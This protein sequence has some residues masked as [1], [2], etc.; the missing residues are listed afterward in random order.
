[1]T[2]INALIQPHLTDLIAIRH[3]LHAHPE[4]GYEEHR[5]S[6]VV[7]RELA[8]AGVDFKA[9]LA[10]GTGVLAHLPGGDGDPIA[11]RADMDALPIVEQTGLPYAS[12]T[13]GRMHAC[14]HDGHTAILIGVAQVLAAMAKEDALPRPVTLVFQPAEEG[15]AGGARMVQDGCLDGSV[16]GPA[17]RSIFG[18]HGWPALGLGQVASRPGPILASADG[19]EA[20]ITGRGGHAAMPHLCIDPIA[21][22]AAVI[23]SAQHVI[24]RKVDPVQG[25]VVSITRVEGGTT[26]NIIPETVFM[27][28]TTRFLHAEAGEAI[29]AAFKEILEGVAAAHGC[30]AEI[31]MHEG[32][33]ITF[34]DPEA[35][36]WWQRIAVATFGPQRVETMAPVMGGE[37]FSYY[38]QQ[39][40]ACFFA[41]GLQPEGA[42]SMPGLHHPCFD[43]NDDAI[44]MGIEAFVAVA[45]H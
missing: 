15:G 4:L 37:D 28:G 5:T 16:L 3:D 35:Y 39:I 24:A 20:T 43:F 40:P 26:H 10:G 12:R 32:Y 19:F 13:E 45:C 8:A 41:L 29:H 27:Q 25:G 6:E 33:P 38:G 34:N 36:A 18:L 2:D 23:Q 7:Q 42:G 14:G 17:V 11:L 22:A 21:A 44:P 9:G 1:M 30:T 31:T